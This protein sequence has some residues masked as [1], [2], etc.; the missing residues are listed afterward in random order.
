MSKL[1]Q[2][3]HYLIAQLGA[4]FTEAALAIARDFARREQGIGAVRERKLHEIS[5]ARMLRQQRDEA[6]RERDA[7]IRER[8]VARE[9]GASPDPT[10]ARLVEAALALDDALANNLSGV[11]HAHTV[12]TAA[13]RHY[14][15]AHQVKP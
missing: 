11:L 2:R 7:A 12:V 13:A 3:A 9:L 14:R 10:T 15:A 4:P 5:L 1:T 6:L 8:D